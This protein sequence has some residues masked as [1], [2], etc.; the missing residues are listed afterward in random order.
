MKMYFISITVP[1]IVLS[2]YLNP[3]VRATSSSF[4]TY[5]NSTKNQEKSFIRFSSRNRYYFW[6]PSRLPLQVC[7]HHNTS[8][9]LL[10]STPKPFQRLIRGNGPEWARMLMPPKPV[11]MVHHVPPP[12]FSKQNPTS[13]SAAK[14]PRPNKEAPKVRPAS[15]QNGKHC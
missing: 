11:G 13:Y 8:N 7:F 2:D 1:F 6:V 15:P 12:L 9:D 10:S 5:F 3:F 4:S 14:W